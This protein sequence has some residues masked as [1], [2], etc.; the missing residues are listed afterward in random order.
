[1]KGLI[2]LFSS[3]LLLARWQNLKIEDFS[4]SLLTQHYFDIS[5]Q[6]LTKS[7]VQSL[8]TILLSERT[9]EDIPGLLKYIAQTATNFLLLTAGNTKT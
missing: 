7:L 9:P 5:T 2:Q 6:N 8:L 4:I 3:E 1:M